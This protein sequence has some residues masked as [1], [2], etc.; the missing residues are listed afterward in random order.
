MKDLIILAADKDLK[1]ALEALLKRN[2]ALHIRS[3]TFDV[4]TEPGH[5]PACAL[6][7]VQFLNSLHGQHHHALLMFDYEG[8]GFDDRLS[9]T[10]LESQLT[11]E[12]TKSQWQDRAKA[13]LLTPELEAW[14]WSDSSHVS[15]VIGWKD[16]RKALAD[17]LIQ[18]GWL[19]QGQ[20]KPARPKE[21]FDAALCA[22]RQPHSSSLF[23][24]LA[25][26]VSF[27][28]CTDP[29]FTKFCQTLRGWFP[30]ED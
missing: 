25:E 29:S 9:P 7:G 5:D 12:F 8:S 1:T 26:K 28:S 23:G 2:Q 14:V 13:I 21:A 10:E 18:N 15:D 20:T 27:K 3:I 4:Y 19:A 6:Q 11:I 24:R 22:A 30:R 16:S 17:W